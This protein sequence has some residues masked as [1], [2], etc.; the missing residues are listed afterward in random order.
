LSN[1]KYCGKPAGFLRNKHAEC[2]EQ[3]RQRELLVQSGCAQI[4]SESLK[5]IKN[6][7]SFDTLETKIV[8]IEQ[9]H[10]VDSEKRKSLL[11]NTWEQTVDNSLDD[12]ILGNAVESRLVEFKNY[13]NLFGSNSPPLGGVRPV[14]DRL[15]GNWLFIPRRLRRGA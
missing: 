11:I 2:E 4:I 14:G 9:S 12:G 5:A 13:F 7:A 8:E 10:F 15:L 3:H 6:S 1:C